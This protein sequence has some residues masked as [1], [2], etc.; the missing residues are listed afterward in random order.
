M[1]EKVTKRLVPGMTVNGGSG[2]ML[3]RNRIEL[4]RTYVEMRKD[5]DAR[6]CIT[7]GL[8]MRPRSSNGGFSGS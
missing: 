1:I 6:R 3:T 4:G 2:E 5:A 7:E 8:A